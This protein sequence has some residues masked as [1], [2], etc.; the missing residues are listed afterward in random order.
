MDAIS[1]RQRSDYT[2]KYNAKEGRFG[3]LRLTPAYSIKVVQEILND[4]GENISILDP[5]SGTATTPLL[6]G[7]LGYNSVGIEIN[8]FLAWFGRIKTTL[9]DEEVISSAQT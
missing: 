2:F 5:F 4:F 3:W 9:Y 1:L 7:Y 6:A 8:P